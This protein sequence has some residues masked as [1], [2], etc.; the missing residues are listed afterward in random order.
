MTGVTTEASNDLQEPHNGKMFSL[1]GA[2]KK[3]FTFAILLILTYFLFRFGVIA[4]SSTI[5]V[6][7]GLVAGTWL[8][9]RPSEWAV[10]GIE[11]IAGH[12]GTSR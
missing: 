4:G 2:G 6:V 8:A 7:L 12:M 9:F 5:I 1:L 11:S 3:E 10:E